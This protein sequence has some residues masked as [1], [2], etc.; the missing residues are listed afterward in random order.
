[1]LSA[2]ARSISEARRRSQNLSSRFRFSLMLIP[3]WIMRFFAPKTLISTALFTLTR[4]RRRLPR[5][6]PHRTS[7]AHTLGDEASQDLDLISASLAHRCLVPLSPP[8][9]DACLLAHAPT[10]QLALQREMSP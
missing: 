9:I 3:F 5:P 8:S 7:L 1:M 6:R 2:L 10:P 4:Y